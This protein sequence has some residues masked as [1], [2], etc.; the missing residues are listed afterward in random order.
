MKVTDIRIL[1]RLDLLSETP[2]LTSKFTPRAL[3]RLADFF[4]RKSASK[5]ISASG[6]TRTQYI[7][8]GLP[9]KGHRGHFG[10]DRIW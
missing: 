5:E 3:N 7:P 9:Q 8:N 6:P 10:A 1:R 2:N 4:N